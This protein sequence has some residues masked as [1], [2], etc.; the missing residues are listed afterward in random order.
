VLVAAAR[1]FGAVVAAAGCGAALL[2]LLIAAAAHEPVRRGL[3]IGFYAAGAGLLGLGVLLGVSPPVRRRDGDAVGFGRWV[4]R[5]VRWASRSEHDE[6]I[7]FPAL[8]LTVGLLLIVL[9]IAVD[10]PPAAA[11]SFR[12]NFWEIRRRI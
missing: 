1:R 10:Q 12:A 7:N 11:S 5:G 2:G 8:L 9:G 6:A 3:A 4:G